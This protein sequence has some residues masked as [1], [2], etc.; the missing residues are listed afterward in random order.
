MRISSIKMKSGRV[1]RGRRTFGIADWD[2]D[3]K[4][5][6]VMNGANAYIFSQVGAEDGNFYYLRHP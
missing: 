2:G 3:G 1:F 5:D 4:Q 6:L